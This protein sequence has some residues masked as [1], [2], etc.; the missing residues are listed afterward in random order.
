VKKAMC[1][2]L[3]VGSKPVGDKN[4]Y[5]IIEI[6]T[7]D[8][9][10]WGASTIK[11]LLYRLP[12]LLEKKLYIK[13]H[14]GLLRLIKISHQWPRDISSAFGIYIQTEVAK[15]RESLS[16]ANALNTGAFIIQQ[17]EVAIPSFDRAD[18]LAYLE[19]N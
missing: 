13:R 17:W 3:W 10:N 7:I 12:S 9:Q 1:G 14:L 15:Q 5:Y 4:E 8:N 18:Y 16:F 19:S 6:H 2:K 11:I